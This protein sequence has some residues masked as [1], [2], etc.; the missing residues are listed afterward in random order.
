MHPFV[1]Y[2][3]GMKK[4]VFTN[5]DQKGEGKKKSFVLD[6]DVES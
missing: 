1:A 2:N 5:I 3:L 6:L 4:I